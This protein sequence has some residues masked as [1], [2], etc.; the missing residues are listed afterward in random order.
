[1]L[2]KR[3]SQV[4]TAGIAA[5]VLLSTLANVASPVLMAAPVAQT[6]G[7]KEV[8]GVLTGGQFAKIWLG[9]TPTNRGDNVTL[10]TE[11]DQNFPDAN[12]L[13]FFVLDQDGLT[14]VRNGSADV[15]DANL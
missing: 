11:W 3:L 5:T 14:S 2:Y 15:R 7:A 12:G 6:I 1:M 13:G 4:F 9:L 8:S 10:I